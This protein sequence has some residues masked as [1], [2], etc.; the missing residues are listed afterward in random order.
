MKGLDGAGRSA[1]FLEVPRSSYWY[2]PKEKTL[3]EQSLVKRMIELSD[4]HPRYGY[5]RITALLRRDGF[6]INPKRVAR[7]RRE[8]GLKVSK[9][10]KRTRGSLHSR[11]SE[12][13]EAKA[14]LE[15][16]LRGGSDR[17]RKPLQDPYLD[18]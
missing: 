13:R 4:K 10:Q 7:I 3:W 11:A 17:E 2:R 12:G 8:E 18:R 5:R 1:G 6:E 9:R 14:R 16:G 15:L